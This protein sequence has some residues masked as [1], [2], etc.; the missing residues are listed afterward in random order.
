MEVLLF[1]LILLG[2]P[3]LYLYAKCKIFGFSEFDPIVVVVL[4]SI[5]AI[6]L[7]FIYGPPDCGCGTETEIEQV[8]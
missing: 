1:I 2:L 3:A 8:K 4:A 5:I 7:I 6:F